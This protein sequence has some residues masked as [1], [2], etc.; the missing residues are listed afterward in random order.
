MHEARIQF[1]PESAPLSNSAAQYVCGSQH[2]PE[3]NTPAG[4]SEKGDMPGWLVSAPPGAA[5]IC[6]PRDRPKYVVGSSSTEGSLAVA[7]WP[8]RR[9]V[10]R[11]RERMRLAPPEYS[12]IVSLTRCGLYRKPSRGGSGGREGRLGGVGGDGGGAGSGGGDGLEGGG[13]GLGG[14]R[15]RESATTHHSVGHALG[16][17]VPRE[18]PGMG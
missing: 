6:S 12:S 17:G 10:K 7:L 18:Q 8:K 4:H 2:C 11:G 9:G 14:G 1:Q 15:G 5:D 13:G 16:L 3:S